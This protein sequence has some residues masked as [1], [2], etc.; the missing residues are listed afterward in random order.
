MVFLAVD[1]GGDYFGDMK[2]YIKQ[3]NYNLTYA[4]SNAS[5]GAAYVYAGIPY[6]VIIDKDGTIAFIAQGSYRSKTYAVMSAVLDVV[7]A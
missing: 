6:D 1:A 7:D 3:H 2:A 4:L 5:V